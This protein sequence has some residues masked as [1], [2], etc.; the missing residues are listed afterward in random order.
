MTYS[1][2]TIAARQTL[3]RRLYRSTTGARCIGQ[4]QAVLPSLSTGGP[5]HRILIDCISPGASPTCLAT[6]P[7][8]SDP[9]D[10]RADW[11]DPSSY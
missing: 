4:P 1:L 6:V 8:P 11:N 7:H 5:Q 10:F 3:D 2:T 9:S